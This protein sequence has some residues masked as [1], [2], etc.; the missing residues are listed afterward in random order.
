MLNADIFEC[1]KVL[2]FASCGQSYVLEDLRQEKNA[3][4]LNKCKGKDF[5]EKLLLCENQN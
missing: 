5:K 1:L 4:A 3:N 2:I